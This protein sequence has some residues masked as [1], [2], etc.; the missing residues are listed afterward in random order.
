MGRIVAPF[1][2]KGWVKLKV[3]TETPDSLLNYPAW[4][5]ATADG[6]Q[7]YEVA[8]AE[9]HAKG[10]VVRLGGVADR[11]GGEALSGMDVGVP[12]EAF[13]EPRTDEFYWTD[14]IGTEV[15]NKQ[16]EALGKVEGL[17]ETGANDV[18]VVRGDRERLIPYVAAT[19][20]T[21]DLQSRRIVVDWDLDY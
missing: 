9:F 1:G 3:F 6:W 16:D 10:L 11:A 20:V 21:V 5:L 4:W 2:V 13:P 7:K 18:L 8:E 19:I 12:R 14:L 17:L 15:V